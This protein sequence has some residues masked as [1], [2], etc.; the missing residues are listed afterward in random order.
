MK[1]QIGELRALMEAKED[2]EAI[3]TKS[4]A[5]QQASLKLFEAVYKNASK[6]QSA[7]GASGEQHT[8]D[9]KSQDADFKEK[10]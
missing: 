1:T 6:G 10:K 5:V 9:D 7:P 2:A 8:H 3:R 4:S